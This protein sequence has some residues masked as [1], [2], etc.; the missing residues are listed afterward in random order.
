MYFISD[1][2]FDHANIIKY[3]NRPFKSVNDMNKIMIKNFL[4]TV[5]EGETCYILGDIFE[6][7][8]LG[9]FQ[10]RKLIIILGN[11]DRGKKREEAIYKVINDFYLDCEICKYPILIK[12]FLWLSHEPIEFMSPE[13][14]YL[15]IHGHTHITNPICG[16]SSLW[17]DGNR[18]FNVS[19]E[20]LNYTP[21]SLKDI[22]KRLGMKGKDLRY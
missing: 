16:T 15:N 10:N 12:K 8:Y 2:H 6:P 17:K 4:N 14:P 19:V 1:F 21:I 5:K 22:G 9:C 18:F 3:C 11:H 13:M 7:R 20:Q